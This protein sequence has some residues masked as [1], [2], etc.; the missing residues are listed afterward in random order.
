MNI[1]LELYCY[2]ELFISGEECS[3]IWRNSTESS[4]SLQGLPG[5]VMFDSRK[6][7]RKRPRMVQD[8][9]S[10]RRHKEAQTIYSIAKYIPMDESQLERANQPI[11]LR[12]AV[13]YVKLR[14]LLQENL[15]RDHDFFRCSPQ[16]HGFFLVID[17]MGTIVYASSNITTLLGPHLIDVIG[18][19]FLE[20]LHAEDRSVLKDLEVR[21]EDDI[22][23]LREHTPTV[24]RMKTNMSPTVRSQ[25]KIQ[26]KVL[27]VVYTS[28]SC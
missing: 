7:T 20:L 18:Q 22:P 26:Y 12:L 13:Q 16:F 4:F 9:T 10:V 21:T 2:F 24:L 5:V 27:C 1:H 6:H 8:T 19:D 14:K 17:M 23:K 3:Y 25:A 15:L 11:V 28:T